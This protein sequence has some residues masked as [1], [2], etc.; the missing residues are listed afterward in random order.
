MNTKNRLQYT[1]C[2]Y[3]QCQ[4]VNLFLTS[5][6]TLIQVSLLEFDDDIEEE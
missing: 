2:Q 4:N 6:I 3:E 1:H 5:V